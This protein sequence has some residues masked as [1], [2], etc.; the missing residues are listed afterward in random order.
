MKLLLLQIK[1]RKTYKR[2]RYI[3]DLLGLIVEGREI[4]K[5]IF[6]GNKF[7]KYILDL[8][9]IT[10]P[11]SRANKDFLSNY[12]NDNFIF[13]Y[14]SGIAKFCA[15]RTHILIFFPIGNHFAG[16]YNLFYNQLT[17]AYLENSTGN[18]NEEDKKDKINNSEKLGADEM[19]DA[20]INYENNNLNSNNVL[21]SLKKYILSSR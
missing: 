19:R 7:V 5:K 17:D 14:F 1:R 4:D 10:V 12:Y 21:P 15:S 18:V 13:G 3:I 8:F 16:E 9:D 2:V 20:W 6:P 11:I